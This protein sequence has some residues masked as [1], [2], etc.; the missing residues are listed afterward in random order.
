VILH[1]L[2]LSVW[3]QGQCIDYGRLTAKTWPE[4]GPQCLVVGSLLATAVI[5]LA[6]GRRWSFP[7]LA[8]FCLLA[9]T[10]SIVPI[11]DLLFENRMYLP[12]A[13]VVGLATL[14][15]FELL[16]RVGQ[17]AGKYPVR[18]GFDI[19]ALVAVGLVAAALGRATW[20]RN[21]DY[22][23][24]EVFWRDVT[25]KAPQNPRGHLGL[26]RFLIDA[27]RPDEAREYV[28]RAYQAAADRDPRDPRMLVDVG[29][30]YQR[31]ADYPAAERCFRD[32]LDV[33]AECAFGHF[34]LGS[35][36]FAAKRYPEC[37]THLARALELEPRDALHLSAM[38][39]LR[40]LQGRYAESERLLRESPALDPSNATTERSLQA[41]LNASTVAGERPSGR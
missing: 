32:A 24:C 28:R 17:R 16:H 15:G 14:G 21:L 34:H 39:M 9:P 6:R 41:V 7:L 37:E 38:G 30:E 4:Y 13:S 5:G 12:L 22:R 11:I 10:S 27:R 2:R 36:Y 40:E 20:L 3:P 1:Y 25:E 23:T 26:A 35:L 19:A 8:F 31:L 18:R 29:I 33:D